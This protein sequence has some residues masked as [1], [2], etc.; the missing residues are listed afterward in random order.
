MAIL[1]KT[2]TKFGE[3]LG[4]HGE[5]GRWSTVAILAKT[6]TKI[7]EGLGGCLY[8]GVSSIKIVVA[9]RRKGEQ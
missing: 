1:A 6:L 7:G 5:V 2:F 8:L 4:G 9:G 3:G